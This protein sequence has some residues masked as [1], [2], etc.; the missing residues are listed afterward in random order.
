M[1]Q[2]TESG[3]GDLWCLFLNRWGVIHGAMRTV[4]HVVTVCLLYAGWRDSYTGVCS[5]SE[6]GILRTCVL[7]Q[8]FQ[9]LTM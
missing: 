6:C 8:A 5:L 1:G 7:P 9:V 3:A 4:T 2:R